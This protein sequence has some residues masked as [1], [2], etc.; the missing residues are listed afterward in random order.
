MDCEIQGAK[1]V[2]A[3]VKAT[4]TCVFLRSASQ[5]LYIVT[6]FFWLKSKR[7][8]MAI[9]VSFSLLLPKI[10]SGV[11]FQRPSA[12]ICSH[13]KFSINIVPP[14]FGLK[15]LSNKTINQSSPRSEAC[16]RGNEVRSE[17]AR[18][19]P[20]TVGKTC[21]IA[22]CGENAKKIVFLLKCIRD[23]KLSNLLTK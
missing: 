9:L 4:W 10:C 15:L 17:F 23:H 22:S 13:Y 5:N 2:K 20:Q 6:Q 16:P 21:G 3:V 8:L 11:G 12:V 19:L 7:L 18:R 14:V 1:T